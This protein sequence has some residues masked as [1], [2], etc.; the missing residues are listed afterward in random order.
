MPAIQGPALAPA[1][2]VATVKKATSTGPAYPPVTFGA[3]TAAGAPGAATP[4]S[5]LLAAITKPVD[6][7]GILKTAHTQALQDTG[8]I[9]S[10]LRG[11]QAADNAAAQQRA[12]EIGRASLG[13]SKFLSSLNLG[14]GL[15]SSLTQAAGDQASLASGFSGQLQQDVGQQG[16]KVLS[17][18]QAIGAPGGVPSTADKAGN[19]VYGTGGLLPADAMLAAAPVLKSQAD[20]APAALIGQGQQ[21]AVGAIGAGK[22]QAER[23]DPQIAAEAAKLPATEQKYVAQLTTAAEKSRQDA[24][25]NVATAIKLQQAGDTAAATAAYRKAELANRKATLAETKAARLAKQRDFTVTSG[26]KTRH[27]V[28]METAAT[29]KASK[30]IIVGSDKSGRYELDPTTN[31]LVP[32]GPLSKPAKSTTKPAG[33]LTQDETSKLITAWHDGTVS[34]VR[35]PATDKKGK[36]IRNAAG[37]VQYV[38]QSGLAGKQTYPQAIK[39]LIGLGKTPA[40][41]Q[42]AV[43]S[44]YAP[45]DNGRPWLTT[46]QTQVLSKSGPQ[47]NPKTGAISGG[48]G[49]GTRVQVINGHG[50]LDPSQYAALQAKGILP[51]GQLT[52]EGFYVIGA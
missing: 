45:G 14:S 52:A 12:A 13:A 4:Y 49:R 6:T 7:A 16:S 38:S 8:S 29:T 46:A 21:E 50:V 27:D 44:I 39:R 20:Q 15:Q 34:S 10:A 22:Q 26:E 32:L 3:P 2:P 40:E 30:P 48:P 42:T 35:T 43:D 33:S 9:V 17:A 51:D 37:V 23:L 41:A 1:R 24:I 28:A 18:L 11:Q 5:S 19:V 31:T 36:V 25:G 47:V